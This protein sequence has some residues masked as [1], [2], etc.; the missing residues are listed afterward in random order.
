MR[1]YDFALFSVICDR[2]TT[3]ISPRAWLKE[4]AWST[5]LRVCFCLAFY[6]YWVSCDRLMRHWDSRPVWSANG[7]RR[8]S[9]PVAAAWD[10]H[11]QIQSC[12]QRTLCSQYLCKI[13]SDRY[14]VLEN[15]LQSIWFYLLAYSM[16]AETDR[17]MHAF[18]G[19][20]SP[21][22]ACR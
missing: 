11:Q 21:L 1:V 13:I 8:R 5:T 18:S 9:G 20:R 15:V 4:L 22:N 10:W 12:D 7:R 14:H 16:G 19:P 3:D 2:K 6:K 17:F